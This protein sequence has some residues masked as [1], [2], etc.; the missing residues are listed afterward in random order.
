MDAV[1]GL[2]FSAKENK[3]FFS[4]TDQFHAFSEFSDLYEFDMKKGRRQR[5]SRG[6]RLSQP[7]KKENS[8]GDLSASSAAMAAIA[9]PFS[10]CRKGRR[11]RSPAPS[12]GVAQPDISPDGSMVA[13]AVKPEGRTVGDRPLFALP[14]R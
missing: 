13:A 7:V 1:N 8:R 11:G 14:E 3:I 4:A 12:P 6:Q 2:S 5:L 9:W 10:T